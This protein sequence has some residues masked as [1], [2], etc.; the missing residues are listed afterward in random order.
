[1]ADCHEMKLGQIYVCADCGLELQV[2]KE[3]DECGQPSEECGC[4]E[5]CTF[6]CCGKPLALK[7]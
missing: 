3:C 4:T 2:V 7:A 6:E 5:H 1:M